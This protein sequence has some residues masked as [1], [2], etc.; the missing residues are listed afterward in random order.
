VTLT[1]LPAVGTVAPEFTLASTSGTDVT[2]STLRGKR[3]LL[4]FFPAAFTSVCT[5]ELC[6]FSE[7]YGQFADADTV[8][9]PLS[10]D[11]VESLKEFKA[12]ERMTVHL[13]S[14]FRRQVS[15]A[16][17]ALDEG[18]FRAIRAYVLIDAQGVVRWTHAEEHP[19]L[20]RTNEEL[21]AQV[22]AIA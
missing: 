2:L 21:L 19:G 8:V 11:S 14:D 13:L 1:A 5:A 6:A 9:L 7:E 4:A 16:Y 17:G 20:R 12:K 18:R 10:V 15:R 22:K 3:V